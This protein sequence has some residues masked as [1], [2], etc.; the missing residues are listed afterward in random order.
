MRTLN[1]ITRAVRTN[2]PVNAQEL[3]RAVVAYDVLLA[4]LNVEQN[5]LQL[6]EYFKAGSSC[7]VHYAG[8]ANNP[9]DPDVRAWYDAMHEV[10]GVH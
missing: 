1:E 9:D 6:A 4:L 8:P 10:G 7:P 3:R 5:P 2:R